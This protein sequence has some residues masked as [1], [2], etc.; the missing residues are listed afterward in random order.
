VTEQLSSISLNELVRVA[1]SLNRMEFLDFS[2]EEFSQV[3]MITNRIFES[4]N[5]LEENSIYELIRGDNN[6][7]Y[8]GFYRIYEEINRN[9][10]AEIAPNGKADIESDAIFRMLA[11]LADKLPLERLPEKEQAKF[12]AFVRN[13]AQDC[14]SDEGVAKSL[15]LKLNGLV[16]NG[17]F[18]SEKHK[19]EIVQIIVENEVLANTNLLYEM[20]TRGFDISPLAENIDK[21]DVASLKEE[22]LLKIGIIMHRIPSKN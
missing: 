19:K 15:G 4:V 13:I 5:D 7:K 14:S 21:Y 1:V 10:F 22:I 9:L 11:Y 18:S 12:F 6:S 16:S 8:T 3:R 20:A 17:Y 2:G